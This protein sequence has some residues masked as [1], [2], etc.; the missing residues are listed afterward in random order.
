MFNQMKT[1]QISDVMESVSFQCCTSVSLA[2]V[3]GK[4]GGECRRQQVSVD[5]N[6]GL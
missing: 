2:V 1:S 6:V 5:S 3:G 4:S